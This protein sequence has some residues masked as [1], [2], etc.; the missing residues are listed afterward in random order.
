MKNYFTF[1]GILFLLILNSCGSDEVITNPVNASFEIRQSEYFVDEPI[2]FTNTSAGIDKNSVFEWNFGDGNT[3]TSKNP[4]HTYTSIGEGNY[5]IVLKVSHS[6]A[7]S[8]FTKEISIV[9]SGS[10]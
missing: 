2:G 8:D 4:T 5:T 6:E 3:S 9:F 1:F 7:V 10:T